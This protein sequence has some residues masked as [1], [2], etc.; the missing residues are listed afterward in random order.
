MTPE[1]G[2]EG[3]TRNV[4]Q[5]ASLHHVGD[6]VFLGGKYDYRINH[7]YKLTKISH[8]LKILGEI[9]VFW[10]FRCRWVCRR[11]IRSESDFTRPDELG[12]SWGVRETWRSFWW[13]PNI[14]AR[15][16]SRS[17]AS[18]PGFVVEPRSD[19]N[20]ISNNNPYPITTSCT[21]VWFKVA[22]WDSRGCMLVWP[23][24]NLNNNDLTRNRLDS[25]I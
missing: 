22:C 18:H 8:G 11:T 16:P 12:W 7:Y 2:G 9:V 21:C 24:N 15:T 4:Q 10:I 6:D 20:P 23:W 17:M 25:I 3:H 13:W 14:T 5:L 19:S 1:V